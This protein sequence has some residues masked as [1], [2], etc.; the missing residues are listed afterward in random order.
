MSPTEFCQQAM[1][2]YE[3]QWAEASGHQTRH[4]L[5]VKM[6][7]LQALMAETDDPAT[8]TRLLVEGR[9]GGDPFRE[10]LCDELLPQWQLRPS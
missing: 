5:R 6:Q 4:P 1:L 10:L 3:R 9:S 8:F 2:D 7:A